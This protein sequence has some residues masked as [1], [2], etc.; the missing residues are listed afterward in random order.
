M[1]LQLFKLHCLHCFATTKNLTPSCYYMQCTLQ[2]LPWQQLSFNLLTTAIKCM[3]QTYQVVESINLYDHITFSMC[4]LIYS[5]NFLAKEYD[6][7]LLGRNLSILLTILT[8][9]LFT[10]KS[11]HS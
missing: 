2:D 1:G 5:E 4:K 8:V 6:D 9:R 11:L 10:T 7:T 3:C